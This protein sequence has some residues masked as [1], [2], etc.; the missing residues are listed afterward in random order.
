[1]STFQLSFCH[2]VYE[3][4]W[5]TLDSSDT[6]QGQWQVSTIGGIYP[7]WRADGKE[8]YNINPDSGLTAVD[9]V[10]GDRSVQF[11]APRQLLH[12]PIVGGGTDGQQGRQY[13]VARDDDFSLTSFWTMRR[14]SR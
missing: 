10:L 11:G 8:L 13:D 5:R 2:Y 9:V 12:V 14:P 1:L 4:F 6:R 7:A 3:S